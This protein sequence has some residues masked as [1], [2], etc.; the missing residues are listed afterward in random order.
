MIVIGLY[1]LI[2]INCASLQS[3]SNRNPLP[4]P[5]QPFF[6][7]KT[8]KEGGVAEKQHCLLSRGNRLL[9]MSPIRFARNLLN[10]ARGKGSGLD[11]AV[12]Q[13]HG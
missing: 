4:G 2:A 7:R 5:M 13:N 6:T 8:T 3:A 11:S 12:L 9:V 1:Q 10:I